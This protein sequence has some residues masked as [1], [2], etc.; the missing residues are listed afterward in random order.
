[1]ASGC[2]TAYFG[3]KGAEENAFPL[4][5]YH[6]AVRLRDHIESMFRGAVSQTDPDRRKAMLTFYIV[7]CGFTGVEMAGEL[8]E[9]VPVLCNKFHIDREEVRIFNVDVLDKIMYI[10]PDKARNRAMRRLEKLGITVKLKTNI[11]GV[12]KDS[13]EYITGDVASKDCTNTVIWAAGIQGSDIAQK[14]EALGLQ[15]ET[16]GRIATDKYLRSLTHPSVYAAGDNIFYIP[17]GEDNPVPQMVEN[18]EHCAP[19]IAE[20]ILAEVSGAQ[21]RREYKPRFHGVM[22]CI[23]GRYGTAHAG[24]PGKFAV[25]PSFIAMLAK[26]FINVVYFMQVLGFNKSIS[27]ITNEFF[28]I[29]NKRSFLG[30][31]FSN[32]GPLFFLLPL[33]LFLAFHFMYSAYVRWATGFLDAPL[34]RERFEQVANA[35]RPIPFDIANINILDQIHF[36]VFVENG[37]MNLWLQKT[38]VSWFLTNFVVNTPANEMFWQYAIVIFEALLAGAFFFGLFTTLASLGGIFAMAVFMLTVGLAQPIW[39]VV[40]ASF[41]CLFTGSRILSLDYY[42]M[43]WLKARWKKCRFV[44][45]WYLFID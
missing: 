4:W 22:I 8:A 37:F 24:L 9:Y 3:V 36:M 23:G 11:T 27:Y 43:P 26:H 13:I 17:E 6:D 39:W 1:M 2:K 32:R 20:N 38:S 7:G 40:F 28:T 18:C 33:R 34:L 5:S 42:V 41:A 35:F 25:L 10:L 15:P 44:K 30:G 21:P 45:K 16:R 31:H 14:S 19:V 12:D 29:R